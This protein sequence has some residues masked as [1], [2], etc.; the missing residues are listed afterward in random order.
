M[1]QF[2]SDKNSC[3]IGKPHL[4][5]RRRDGKVNFH[6]NFSGSCFVL[7]QPT[8]FI[9]S[10]AIFTLFSLSALQL[11]SFSDG[12]FS[13]T[14]LV[15]ELFFPLTHTPSAGVENKSRAFV[16]SS[17]AKLVGWKIVRGAAAK[18]QQIK[19]VENCVVCEC[20][21]LFWRL[22]LCLVQCLCVCAPL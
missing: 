1:I 9:S 5:G 4:R 7:F 10:N 11:R 22:R 18:Q 14:L 2:L 8:L 3:S 6:G 16:C 15:G 21:R 13:C 17:F 20:V 19:S 12:F